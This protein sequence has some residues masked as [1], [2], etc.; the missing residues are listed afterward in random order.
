M[1]I[2]VK[3][4]R[5]SVFNPIPI[6]LD[7]TEFR[8]SIERSISAF[9][10][11]FNNAYKV[12]MDLNLPITVLNI[13]GVLTDDEVIGA[14]GSDAVASI[15]TIG[16]YPKSNGGESAVAQDIR[17]RF[18]PMPVIDNKA[19]YSIG[20]TSIKVKGPTPNALR[21]SDIFAIGDKLY[22]AGNM[23]SATGLLVSNTTITAVDNATNT[24]TLGGSGLTQNIP[25]NA[26]LSN[27][28]ADLFLHHQ[29]FSLVPG[30]WLDS[31]PNRPNQ[32]PPNT[33][34]VYRFDGNTLSQYATGGSGVPTF[35]AGTE[36][37]NGGIPTINIPIGGL[38]NKAGTGNPAK[39]LAQSI[40]DG[41]DCSANI[42]GLST[43]VAGG[44]SS[45]SAFNTKMSS[46]S[47]TVTIS[48]IDEGEGGKSIFN[49][50]GV[51]SPSGG[52]GGCDS[53]LFEGVKGHRGFDGFYHRSNMPHS[54]FSGGKP[55]RGGLSAGDKAQD[56]LGIFAN[57]PIT[58]DTSLLGIQVPYDSLI[59]SSTVSPEVRNFFLTY[60]QV[61]ES[62]K[63]S[64]GN[65]RKAS[66][67][68]VDLRRLV[69]SDDESDSILEPIGDYLT[70]DGDFFSDTW[71]LID[72][73]YSGFMDLI[74]TTAI[75]LVNPSMGNNGGITIIP[76]RLNIRYDAGERH[77]TYDMLLSAV[78]HKIAI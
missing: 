58:A 23:P 75:A 68:M 24:L 17:K 34:I 22:V 11:P 40:K 3:L 38:Y 72:G 53:Q 74:K 73:V 64:D 52:T 55:V 77:Y 27:T 2:P 49:T 36:P 20:D 28:N 42:T 54:N 48:R 39:S 9:A 66:E 43:A 18:I 71:D 62:A 12:G 31:N 76:A 46:D 35:V 59:Q 1:A 25:P 45:A 29:G 7:A 65:S 51:S 19:G 13:T 67:K 30:L 32:I 10:L 26:L 61:A 6:Y 56:L 5:G 69:E 16:Y 37:E 44:R 63:I 60:G 8:I 47:Y 4:W 78:N 14:I 33:P 21:L 15:S 41:I 70:S 50:F 57:S